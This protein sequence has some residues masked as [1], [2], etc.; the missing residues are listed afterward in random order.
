MSKDNEEMQFDEWLKIGMERK[1]V[2]PP[3]CS[4]HDG[5][6]TTEDEDGAWDEGSDPCIHVL[7][8]YVDSLEALLVEQNHSASVWRKAGWEDLP[9][10][11]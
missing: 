11:E 9:T 5:I 4:T 1:F 6:P 8:L 10:E 2:G 3:V 7:R